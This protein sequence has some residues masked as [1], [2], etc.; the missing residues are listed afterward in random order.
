MSK[1]KYFCCAPFPG[2][3]TAVRLH[4]QEIIGLCSSALQS[5]SWQSKAQAAAA[6]ST[7]V[8]RQ[9]PGL[10]DR[11]HLDNLLLVILAVVVVCLC[12]RPARRAMSSSPEPPVFPIS[13]VRVTKGFLYKV[14]FFI[15]FITGPY[16]RTARSYLG[17]KRAIAGGDL[18]CVRSLCR[19]NVG[20]RKKSGQALTLL[21]DIVV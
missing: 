9:R 6:M 17:R 12:S 14:H 15:F 19:Q 13:F 2:S 10:I 8:K 7:V 5:A 3:E 21:D 20:G 11:P 4:L 18:Q 16:D 1:D